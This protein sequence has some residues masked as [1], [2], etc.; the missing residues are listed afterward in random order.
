M[1][2]TVQPG[3]TAI[4]ADEWAL[5]RL[6]MVHALR[7]AGV[8]VLADERKGEDAVRRAIAD[9]VTFLV[10]GLV[11]DAPMAD[12]VRRARGAEHPVRHVIVLFDS[13]T[14]DELGGVVSLGAD[15][16][17]A[18][19]L[20]PEELV[21]AL[22]RISQ[23][24][25]VVAPAF[26]PLLVGLLGPAG[27]EGAGHT[28]IEALLTRKE[29]EVLAKLALGLANKEIADALFI[30]P[31]TVKTHLA[32]IYVKLTVA[33]RQEAVAKAVSLGILG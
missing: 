23:G 28:D 4:V 18:R 29:I 10:L 17:L 2:I 11:R 27:D 19:S 1:A 12:L 9:G 6:G 26:V 24:E 31:A 33:N 15:A 25:R 20:Q 30:T 5:V 21:D 7:S 8:R 32:H 3:A 14:R 13:V 22:E 16:L